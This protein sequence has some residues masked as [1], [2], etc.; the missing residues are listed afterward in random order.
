MVILAP[1]APPQVTW[2]PVAET[3]APV[4]EVADKKW[5]VVVLAA[6]VHPVKTAATSANA[7]SVL[8]NLIRCFF[9]CNK[10]D[11][12]IGSFGGAM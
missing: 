6:L 1:V 2:L 11:G 5:P 8:S 4:L 9:R 10:I 12:W 7:V 3:V